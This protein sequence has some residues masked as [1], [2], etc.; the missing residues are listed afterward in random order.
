MTRAR[1]APTLAELERQC[2]AFNARC[3]LGGRVAV[4]L[5]FVDTPK[6]TT[7][8]TPATVLS[9]HSAVVWLDGVSG[10]Y[11]LGCVTPLPDLSGREFYV[12][13]LAHTNRE[14]AYISVWRPDNAG[15]A[16]PL[17][18]AGKY[19]AEQIEA[20]LD[21]YHRGDSTI[22]VPCEVLDAISVPPTKGTID[23]DAGPIVPN[24]K[25][26]W[27]DILF[28]PIWP[29]AHEPKPQYK[30]ARRAKAA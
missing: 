16:W 10:C 14:H 8:R 23:N 26:S 17:S 18:W 22:A 30:G 9:G 5:D 25:G 7:T 13:S 29:L 11:D 12:V 15:Y 6:I 20:N 21:Y 4:K 1:K 3:A 28:A 24:T 27:Y 19:T 2:E